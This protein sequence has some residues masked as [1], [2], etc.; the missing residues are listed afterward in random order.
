MKL[1]MS[2]KELKALEARWKEVEREAGDGAKKI[3]SLK[4]EVEKYRRKVK[5]CGWSAEKEQEHEAALRTAKMELRQAT[6]VWQHSCTSI[7]TFSTYVNRK[8]TR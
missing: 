8:E 4:L 7:L 1:S 5:E 6:E 2:Q 3:E